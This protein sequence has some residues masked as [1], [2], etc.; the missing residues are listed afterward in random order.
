MPVKRLAALALLTIVSM[1]A[2]SEIEKLATPT[3]HGLSLV[4]WP[5]IG[6]IDGWTHDDGASLANG[7][8]VWVPKGQT[9][10][11]S[12]SVLYGRAL[13]KPR[14]DHFESLKAFIKGD[15]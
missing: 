11:D 15:F 12:S 6:P 13:Y 3:E 1:A 4:W 9:F 14:M 8:N 2:Y 5:K 7:I 10:K